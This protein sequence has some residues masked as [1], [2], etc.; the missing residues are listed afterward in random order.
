MALTVGGTYERHGVQI[1]DLLF[2]GYLIFLLLR[3]IILTTTKYQTSINQS[4][5][6][7]IWRFFF[8]K[9]EP[10]G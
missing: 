3:H 10:I 8:F 2:L 4:P 6:S 1:P 7:E 9:V 5:K